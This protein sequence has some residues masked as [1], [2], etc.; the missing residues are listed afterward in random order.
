[1]VDPKQV[2]TKSPGYK[3]EKE[4]LAY[5]HS[6]EIVPLHLSVLDEKMASVRV[7]LCVWVA[8]RLPEAQKNSLQRLVV[9]FLVLTTTRD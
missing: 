4:A 3:K 2:Y 5:R 9:Y 8:N 6:Q 1:M 7:A